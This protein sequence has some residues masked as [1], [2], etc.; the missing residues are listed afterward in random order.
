MSTIR[1]GWRWETEGESGAYRLGAAAAFGLMGMALA[2]RE[3]HLG[4][5][6]VWRGIRVVPPEAPQIALD[7]DELEP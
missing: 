7:D 3:N 4:Y 6:Q 2:I 5:R 1:I